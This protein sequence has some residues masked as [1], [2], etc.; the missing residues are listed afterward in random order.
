MGK[1]AQKQ[2]RLV[3]WVVLV[4]YGFFPEEDLQCPKETTLKR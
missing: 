4:K 3:F 1:A 2:A